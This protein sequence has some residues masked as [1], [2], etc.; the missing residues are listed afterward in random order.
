MNAGGLR[1]VAY[2]CALLLMPL[3]ATGEDRKAQT[4]DELAKIYDV[5]SCKPCHKQIYEDWEKSLHAR[6]IIGTRRTLDSFR[7]MVQNYLLGGRWKYAGVQKIEDLKTEHVIQCLECHVPQIKDATDAVAREIAQAAMNG[8]MATL[9]KV[10]INCLVC[11]NKKAILHQWVDGPP[12]KD[13]IYGNVVGVHKDAPVYN[14]L[15]KSPI[16]KETIFCGQCH[17][18]GPGFHHPNPAQCA[19]LYGSYMHAYVPAGG[20]KTCQDC[21]M[22]KGHLMSSYRDPDRAKNAVRVEVDTFAYY[23]HPKAFN[24]IPTAVVNVKLTSNAGHRIPDG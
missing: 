3:I 4:V 21:H 9:G 24:W 8:D 1:L 20:S 23:F 11:H 18:L 7:N 2:T 17:G 19:T 15:K 5:S 12:E 22:D 6:S 10:N 14:T 16:M 13:V